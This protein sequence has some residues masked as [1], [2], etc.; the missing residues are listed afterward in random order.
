[1]N[2]LEL[3]TLNSDNHKNAMDLKSTIVL[4]GTW[5]QIQ[6]GPYAPSSLA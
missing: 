1:M 6:K 5:V 2:I 3:H 4:Y